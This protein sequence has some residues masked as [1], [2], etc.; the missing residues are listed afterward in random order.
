MREQTFPHSYVSLNNVC[1]DFIRYNNRRYSIVEL[2]ERYIC[3]E[4]EQN[5]EIRDWKITFSKLL[6]IQNRIY[7]Y[8][9][10]KKIWAGLK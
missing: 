10:G 3:G 4:I 2:M 6:E 9:G 5:K 1:Y 8:Y 7:M